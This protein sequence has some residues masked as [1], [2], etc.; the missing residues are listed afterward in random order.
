MSKNMTIRPQTDI[1]RAGWFGAVLLLW[2]VLLVG[3][4]LQTF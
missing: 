3:G 2:T 4:L 1:S